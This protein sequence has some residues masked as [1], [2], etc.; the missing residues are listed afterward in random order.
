MSG[1]DELTVF[2]PTNAAFAELGSAADA[3]VSDNDALTN[4]LLYHVTAGSV[5]AADLEC[6]GLVPMLQGQNS[7][8]VCLGH[9]GADGIFQ[10]GGSNP[11]SDMPQIVA[12]DIE[13]CNGVIHVV[14]GYVDY[15]S[16]DCCW[17]GWSL[18]GCLTSVSL[19]VLFYSVLLP[20]V[21][22]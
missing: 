11:R 12:T 17:F 13:A 6:T 10:K 19:F 8:T 20:G 9:D 14:D 3:I 7:R 15:L 16:G 21:H 5:F 4:V 22:E 1:D 18:Y 2:A